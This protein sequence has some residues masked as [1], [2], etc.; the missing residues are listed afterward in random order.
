MSEHRLLHLCRPVEVRS[1]ERLDN[2]FQ[3]R[4]YGGYTSLDIAIAL[5]HSGEDL[6]TARKL[7]EEAY[8]R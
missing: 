6:E 2:H 5:T 8:G 1:Q 4:M 7:L 3:L